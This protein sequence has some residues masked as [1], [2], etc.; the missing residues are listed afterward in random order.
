MRRTGDGRREA[1]GER[2]RHIDRHTHKHSPFVPINHVEKRRDHLIVVLRQS[3]DADIGAAAVG[4]PRL[5]HGELVVQHLLEV[6][7]ELGH[8]DLEEL[9]QPEGEEE[10]KGREKGK[11]ERRDVANI[12]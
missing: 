8:V 7:Y 4:G 3:T 10:T 12:S 2:N 1:G 6:G 5:A 9:D 11:R